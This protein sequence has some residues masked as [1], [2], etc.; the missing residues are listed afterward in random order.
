MTPFI[1][2]TTD[3]GIYLRILSHKSPGKDGLKYT[4]HPTTGA[5]VPEYY[6]TGKIR[7]RI[8]AKSLADTD[9]NNAFSWLTE[10]SSRI[11]SVES[12]EML[13]AFDCSIVET[14]NIVS[15]A[16]IIWDDR[17]ASVGT[18]E[19]VLHWRSSVLGLSADPIEHVTGTGT[20]DEIDDIGFA[21]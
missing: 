8:Q 16:D 13:L 1:S 20:V 9:D 21:V 4:P 18:F 15:M 6:S 10:L 17:E 14:D 12:R 19:I 11:W 3:A 5:L 2:N 7:L